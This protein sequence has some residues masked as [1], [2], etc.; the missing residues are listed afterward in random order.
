M[1]SRDAGASTP[2]HSTAQHSQKS[3]AVCQ[4]LWYSP[5]FQLCSRNSIIAVFVLFE[6]KKRNKG[7]QCTYNYH[8][9]AVKHHVFQDI[10]SVQLI[11]T[12]KCK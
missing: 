10:K 9:P 2:P 7:C 5:T 1:D 11:Q 4:T 12:V 8:K 6:K 3:Q